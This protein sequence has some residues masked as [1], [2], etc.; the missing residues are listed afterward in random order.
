MEPGGE[1]RRGDAA[2]GLRDG[3]GRSRE[4][5]RKTEMSRYDHE[6]G[7]IHVPRSEWADLKKAVRDA[8]N[9]LQTERHEFAIRFHAALVASAKG[10]RNADWSDLG[11]RLIDAW[12]SGFPERHD[13]VLWRIFQSATQRLSKEAGRYVDGA[14]VRGSAGRPP[15]PIRTLYPG[16][17]N[18]TLDFDVGEARISFDETNAVV[19][20]RVS[21][22]NK[23][24]EHARQEPVAIAFF[25]ALDRVKWTA[26]TG[27]TLYGNDEYNQE[28]RGG[29]GSGGDY[30]T[31][32]Y[33]NAKTEYEKM[34]AP[35]RSASPST[36]PRHS[37]SFGRGIR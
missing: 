1:G 10:V 11:H 37:F 12:P 16:A 19:H 26:R 4:N 6:Y 24:V 36:F 2:R 29:E 35:S 13:D 33:G 30:V 8:H 22:N 9:A 18:R 34:F 17:T 23:A 27:G 7:E 28:S 20:W 5:E 3:R 15:K 31:A 14:S 25:K 32:R 21:E